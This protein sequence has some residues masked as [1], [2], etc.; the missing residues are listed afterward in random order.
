[1]DH[2]VQGLEPLPYH[3]KLRD[4]FKNRERELWDWFASGKAQE[5]YTETLRLDLLKTTYRLDA[6]NHPELHHHT[7]EARTALGLDIPATLYQGQES[8]HLN[9]VLYFIQGE[10]HVVFTGPALTL[11]NAQELK[12]VIGHELAHYLLWNREEG[13][14]LIADR[15]IAVMAND[16]RAKQSH[17]N[18]ARHYRLYTE[19]FAD[20]GSLRVSGDLNAAVSSLVKMQT[21]LS[22]VS[23]AS[24][25]KQADEIFKAAKVTTEGLSHPEA[26]IRARAL[27]LWHAGEADC[28]QQIS[29]MIEKASSLDDLDLI[30]QVQL[31]EITR[32]VI[33]QLLRPKWFHTGAVMGHAK[34]FFPDFETTADVDAGLAEA[35]KTS[36]PW[37]G[38]YLAYVLLDFVPADPSLDDMPL[39]AAL[40]LAQRLRIDHAFEK[41]AVKELKVKARQLKRLKS[42]GA[43][44]LA[45]AELA[46]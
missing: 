26:F 2:A 13:E 6:E 20:R 42:E 10:G 24:Y 35:L 28:E 43:E 21:G 25:L 12:T 11:L 34:L 41:A 29:A 39:A 22:Q 27:A 9:A 17:F 7:Q 45:K 5:N 3:R 19:I 23:G 40:E 8:A 16:A 33:Q 30:G 31:T 14:F 4:Y 18:S 15:M 46:A 1:M 44:M 32:R 37:L 38:D 36:E